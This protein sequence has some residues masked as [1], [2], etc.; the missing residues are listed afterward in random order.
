MSFTTK[1]GA[2]GARRFR[3]KLRRRLVR[4]RVD[5]KLAPGNRDSI[6]LNF[7]AAHDR[8]DFASY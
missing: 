7:L 1:A 8:S 5:S 4:E 3:K 6:A 2:F